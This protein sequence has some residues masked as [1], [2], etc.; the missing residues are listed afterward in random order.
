M[1]MLIVVLIISFISTIGINTY[2]N[3]RT[4]VQY[5]DAVLKVLSMIKT[6]RESAITS[7]STY[8]P[9][10]C[11]P[12]GEETFVPPEGYG[13]YIERSTVAGQARF[14]LFANTK[15]DD[16]QGVKKNQ[17]DDPKEIGDLCASDLVEEEFQLNGLAV[18]NDLLTNITPPVT[19]LKS[20]ARADEDRVV[21]LFKNPAADTIIAANDHPIDAVDLTLP[22]NLYLQFRRGTAAT[23]SPSSYIHVNQMAGFAEIL[24]Q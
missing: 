9:N 13:V 19:P 8:D 23:G 1:E 6:A 5:N 14:V 16:I 2:R 18:L 10:G 12:A 21:I 11:R 24:N 3:Q 15:A 22:L 4:Q 20:K 7:R 17:F